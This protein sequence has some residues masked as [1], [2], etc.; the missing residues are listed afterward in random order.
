VVLTKENISKRICFTV[1]GFVLPIVSSRQANKIIEKKMQDYQENN[2]SEYEY[3][4]G[5]RDLTF[6]EVHEFYSKSLDQMKSLED[7]ARIS[8]IGV[9]IV[10]SLVTGFAAFLSQLSSANCGTILLKIAITIVGAV[11]LSYLITSGWASLNVLGEK[12][13][14]YQFTPKDTR[15]PEKERINKLA[16]FTELN[17]KLNIER[18]NYVYVAYRSI[19]YAIVLLAIMFI[20]IAISTF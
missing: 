9:T 15:L 4:D 11:S 10:V 20:L 3:M 13:K 17:V 2:S 14:V 8:V 18:N 19:F 12:N 7:K 6:E 5:Y 1:L 16:L